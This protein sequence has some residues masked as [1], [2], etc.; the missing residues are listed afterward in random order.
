M[1]KRVE[2]AATRRKKFFDPWLACIHPAILTLIDDALE[3]ANASRLKRRATEK[4]RRAFR[5]LAIA[6]VSNA[7]HALALGL[8]PP[9]VAVVLAKARRRAGRYDA[10]SM[11]Q[12]DAVLAAIEPSLV[13]VT[14]S[15]KNGLASVLLPGESLNEC[16]SGLEDFGPAS[17]KR[18]SGG[19]TIIVQ[20]V[21]RDYASDTRETVKVDY[22]DTPKTQRMRSELERINAA[23]DSARLEF[24]G[25]MPLDVHQRRLRRIFNTVNDA[26][27]FGLNGRLHGGWWETL[28]R[29]QRHFIRI[30]G[31]PVAD[32]DFSAMFLRLAYAKAGLKPPDGDLYAGI[33]AGSPEEGSYRDGVK[34]IVNAMLARSTRLARFPKGSKELLPKGCSAWSIRED[35][36]ARHSA[37]REQFETGAALSLMRTESDILVAVLLRLIDREIIALPMHD[38]LM[39]RW[40]CAETAAATMREVSLELTGFELPVKM[41]ALQP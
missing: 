22:H 16:I 25:S 35:I 3:L 21:E 11:R 26:P 41:K 20:R 15:H 13:T 27:Q 12:L 30:D 4:D 31:E 24:L 1:L 5:E 38:G 37:I 34:Q 28:E 40:D 17:F 32:L 23:L 6:V 9:S 36:L 18:N 33:I 7:A 8:N 2:R 29:D 39:V 10:A 14:P 19:E